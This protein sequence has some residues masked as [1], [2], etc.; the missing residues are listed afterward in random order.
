MTIEADGVLAGVICVLSGA[1]LRSSGFRFFG[2]GAHP[3]SFLIITQILILTLVGTLVL[4]VFDVSMSYDVDQFISPTTKREVVNLVLFSTSILFVGLAF[5]RALRFGSRFSYSVESGDYAVLKALT[6][7]SLGVMVVKLFAVSEVPLWYALKGDVVA[8]A[9][10]KIRILTNQTGVAL[11]GLNYIFRSFTSYVYLAAVMNY[12]SSRG[13]RRGGWLLIANGILATINALYD[14][15]KQTIVLLGLATGWVLYARAGN[16]KILMKG[17]GVGVM[18]VLFMFVTTLDYGLDQNLVDSALRRVFVSQAE[19]MFLIRESIEPSIKYLWYGMPLGG[20]LGLE[21]VDPAAE[22][23]KIFF[24][25]AGDTWL[26]SNTY[27]IAHAWSIFGNWSV[28]LGPVFVLCNIAILLLF[29]GFLARRISSIFNAVVFWFV[30]KLPLV[31]L[32]T[33]F[34]WLKVALDFAIN[35]L[36]VCF[37]IYSVRWVGRVMS[38]N[39]TTRRA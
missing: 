1:I 15:Q 10:A 29:G 38:S 21:Q 25:T 39:V 23:V 14:V 36:F 26:N 20:Q 37:V 35:A 16:I 34:L 5:L 32:F 28:V 2:I 30:I 33:E 3:L 27:Y 11:F 31:N 7:V 8:A 24:P 22:V 18:L 6:F 9:E 12:A 17:L 19:G 4:A 13:G